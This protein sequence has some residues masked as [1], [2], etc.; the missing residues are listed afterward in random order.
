MDNLTREQRSRT[1]SRIRS[2][3][4]RLE[5]RF[6][7]LLRENDIQYAMHPDI[8]GKPD[9]QIG[10]NLLIFVDSDF[11]HGWNFSRWR[12][13]L[14]QEYWVAKIERNRK[15]DASKFRA[16]RR[17]GYKV[18]RIWSHELSTPHKVIDRITSA[19]AATRQC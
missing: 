8:Y 9:C 19:M 11:W 13:R 12:S 14:P 5:Q 15:R 1:M 4:T 3:G 18:L 7:L 16:L 2:S 10:D 6:F 17:R